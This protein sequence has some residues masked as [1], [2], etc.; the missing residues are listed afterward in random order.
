M[1]SLPTT[2]LRLHCMADV[3]TH[4]YT[5]YDSGGNHSGPASD[6]QE[7]VV[8]DD[9]GDGGFTDISVEREGSGFGATY[10]ST[11]PLMLNN[12]LDFDG[13]DDRMRTYNQNGTSDV[14]LASLFTVDYTAIVAFYPEV[15]S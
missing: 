11:T 6:G 15:I 1:P 4:C 3:N 2:N 13:S 7:V 5:V 12:C 8:W 10:R 9:E 14:T